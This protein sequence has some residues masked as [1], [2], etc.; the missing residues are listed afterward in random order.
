MAEFETEQETFWAGRF[1][2]EYIERNRSASVVAANVALFSHALTRTAP[3]R[4]CIELG[5]NVGLNLRALRTLYPNQTQFAVEINAKAAAELRGHVQ[6][7]R[8]FETS[9]LEF[10]A[11][12]LPHRC[13]LSF[14]K[15]VLIHINPEKLSRAYAALYAASSRY[16]MLAEYYNPSPVSVTYRGHA[17]RLFKRDFAGEMMDAYPDLELLDYGFAYRRDRSFPQDDITWF[18]LE[19]K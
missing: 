9:I 6:A 3:I 17:E 18:L 2:N 13:D 15:G 1:G 11:T 4:S 14:V 19:K 8:V 16:V 7:E 5:A 10:D 12:C